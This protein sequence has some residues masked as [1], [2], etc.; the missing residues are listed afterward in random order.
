MKTLAP[1]TDG[2]SCCKSRR[3]F[4]LSPLNPA[5]VGPVNTS[6]RKAVEVIVTAVFTNERSIVGRR[7]RIEFR[8][9]VT[10]VVLSRSLVLGDT[11]DDMKCSHRISHSTAR[12]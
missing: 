6:S 3:L 5:I 2:P 1:S 12:G 8:E 7:V 9:I 11:T 10:N 4:I